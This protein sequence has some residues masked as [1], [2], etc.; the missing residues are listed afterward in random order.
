MPH[1]QGVTEFFRG[2]V[3]KPYGPARLSSG[4]AVAIGHQITP[5][6]SVYPWVDTVGFGTKFANPATLPP[7][8]VNGAVFSSDASTLFLAHAST[9]F[10]SAY[11]W[12]SSGFGTKY[13]NPAT[14]PS[15][16]GNSVAFRRLASAV[17]DH[18]ALGHDTSIFVG[19][20]LFSK[21]GGGWGAKFGNPA[22]LPDSAGRGV[23]FSPNGLNL[24][25]SHITT[26]FL[27]V[28]PWSGSGFGT[29]Y[30]DASPLP[31]TGTTNTRFSHFGGALSVGQGWDGA[32]NISTYAFVSGTG[33]GT[34]YS[35]PGYAVGFASGALKMTHN[36]GAL[37]IGIGISVSFDQ[38]V[39]FRWS[40]VTG[41]GT[42][43][44]VLTRIPSAVESMAYNLSKTA[45]FLG[46]DA[47]G[48]RVDAY[49]WTNTSGFGTHYSDPV[50]QPT[51][52]PLY[53]TVAP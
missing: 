38:C 32:A 45:A 37:M 9:P 4:S 6:I 40:D 25:V 50:T 46:P 20:W 16:N 8:Q 5:F 35:D 23:D 31:F 21:T 10:V 26:Q 33:M 15:G 41:Y 51:G 53:V 3:G 12:S 48:D 28:Y 19:V 24:A 2:R 47:G 43:Y 18:I 7:A 11:P 36:N 27:S 29:K 52:A 39:G 30:A 14:L 13:A 49:R 44:P 34:K 22:T 1:T 17:S 42:R